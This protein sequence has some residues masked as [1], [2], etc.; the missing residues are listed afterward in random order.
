[1]LAQEVLF[2]PLGIGDVEWM[3]YANGDPIAGWGLRMRPR[4]IAKVASWCSTTAATAGL[5]KSPL[6]DRVGLTLL[7]SYILPAAGH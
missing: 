1:V 2:N 3:R 4:N 7:N 5:Y 6:Q